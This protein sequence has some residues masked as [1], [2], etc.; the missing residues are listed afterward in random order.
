ME[1][2]VLDTNII[3][4]FVVKDN[5]SQYDI[6]KRIFRDI[7]DGKNKAQISLLVLNETT[8]MLEKYYKHNRKD[9]VSKLR[10]L[11][12]LKG[13]D[14]IEIKK[15][16]AMEVLDILEETKFDLTDIYLSRITKKNN[17]LSFDKDFEKLYKLE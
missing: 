15:T 11:F 3:L 1:T 17:L 2:I 13:I 12:S 8:W 6:A 14:F 4:R 16:L 9:F 7:E 10:S 5:K